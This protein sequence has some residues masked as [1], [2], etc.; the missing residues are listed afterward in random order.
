MFWIITSRPRFLI[1]LCLFSSCLSWTKL[2]SISS[3]NFVY[4]FIL[5][6]ISGL[7][8]TWSWLNS[9]FHVHKTWKS[10][11]ICL[12]FYCFTLKLSWSYILMILTRSY[13]T[14]LWFFFC[15]S[16]AYN[17]KCIFSFIGRIFFNSR[18]YII[19]SWS[20]CRIFNIFIIT[21]VIR[22]VSYL[23]GWW[24][25]L[26]KHST[27]CRVL[28]NSWLFNHIVLFILLRI[29]KNCSFSLIHWSKCFA[30]KLWRRLISI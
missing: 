28:R 27:F 12:L 21:R 1:N 7:V 20:W 25:F 22:I 29:I 30:C 14:G 11:I 16:F 23:C 8:R 10:L 17:T 13:I 9:F 3:L 4:Q 5:H 24:G 2:S 18:F 6:C 15:K 19:W 26:R